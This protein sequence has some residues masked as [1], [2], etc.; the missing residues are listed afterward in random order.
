MW[1]CGVLVMAT[2]Q[3]RELNMVEPK[4]YLGQHSAR[5]LSGIVIFRSSRPNVFLK[6]RRIR[7][8]T[9]ELEAPFNLVTGQRSFHMNITKFLKTNVLRIIVNDCF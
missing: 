3:L 1:C 9:P 7:R 2:A 4:L 5:S 6:N 8:K